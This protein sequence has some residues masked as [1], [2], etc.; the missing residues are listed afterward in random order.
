[1]RV[2]DELKVALLPHYLSQEIKILNIS[3]PRLGIDLQHFQSQTMRHDWPHQFLNF[4]NI[5]YSRISLR[6]FALSTFTG[7]KSQISLGIDQYLP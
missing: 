4:L 2:S 7:A 6:Q 5:K 1:M 3:F